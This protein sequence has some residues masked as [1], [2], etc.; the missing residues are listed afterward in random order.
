MTV[1]FAIT[2]AEKI[3][4]CAGTPTEEVYFVAIIRTFWPD[5][6]LEILNVLVLIL[7]WFFLRKQQRNTFLLHQSQN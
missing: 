6:G 1:I 2:D 3:I 7:L 4:K 5:V